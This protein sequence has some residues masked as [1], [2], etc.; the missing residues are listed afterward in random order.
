[1]T[2]NILLCD[3]RLQKNIYDD[4]YSL[5]YQ[6][7]VSII[8][9]VYRLLY[10]IERSPPLCVELPVSLRT[11][12]NKALTK[13]EWLQKNIYFWFSWKLQNGCSWGWWFLLFFKTKQF[14]VFI[15]KT[16]ILILIPVHS[17]HVFNVTLLHHTS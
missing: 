2:Q 1:M 9:V 11:W 6:F 17:K 7:R 16:N 8:S 14:D 5:K 12:M 4:L 3:A 10:P 15:Y 13:Y